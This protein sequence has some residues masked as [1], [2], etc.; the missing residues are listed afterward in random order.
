MNEFLKRP[1]LALFAVAALA[2]P[3]IL[4]A[5]ADAQ[6]L[7]RRRTLVYQGPICQDGNCVPILNRIV[8][9][10]MKCEPCQPHVVPADEPLPEFV[11]VDETADQ[12]TQD[13]GRTAA[14]ARVSNSCGS[15]SLVGFLDNDSLF[16]TNAH[17]SGTRP[18]TDVTLRMRLNG[19]DTTYS[20]KVIMAAYSNQTLA[21]WS[22]VRVPGRVPSTP[23]PL[24]I[25]RPSGD[26]VTVGSPRCVWPLQMQTLR[27]HNATTNSALWQW[28]P[29]AIGGQSGSGVWSPKDGNQ[30]GL[31]TWSWGGYGAGQMTWWIYRQ[32]TERSVAGEP[33]PAGLR[34]LTPRGGV[35]VEEGFFQEANIGTLPIWANQQP[36][37]DPG[38]EDDP[39][40]EITT[41]ERAELAKLKRAAKE[42]NVDWIAVIRLILQLIQLFRSQSSVGYV[43]PSHQPTHHSHAAS[44]HDHGH[45]AA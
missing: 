43:L 40:A 29:N 6:I 44:C 30:Y 42:R 10:A 11:V 21:D 13:W 20:G 18:G 8:V 38:M 26:H 1:L 28:T 23:R 27:T 32:A 9:D 39:C 24:A 12:A 41:A 14:Q 4:T 34:E 2:L 3:M 36:T 7:F 16:L 15:A 25:E 33:R 31:V 37:P 35:I 22:I 5:D 17:V 19:R 45:L